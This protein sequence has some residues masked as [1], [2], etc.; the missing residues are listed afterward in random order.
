MNRLHSFK[1]VYFF[2]VALVFGLSPICFASHIYSYKELQCVQKEIEML[3]A[4]E[5]MYSRRAK[6]YQDKADT[7]EAEYKQLIKQNSTESS[8]DAKSVVIE[9]IPLDV[10]RLWSLA[11]AY[12]QLANRA[13]TSTTILKVLSK[14]IR[15]ELIKE[16]T[17]T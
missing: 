1:L 7:L 2:T 17:K 6:E 13:A 11:S 3:Q 14:S 4:H 10:K 5:K 15:A 12:K 16:D 9:Q 8:R